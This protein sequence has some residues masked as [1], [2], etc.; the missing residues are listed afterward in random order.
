MRRSAFSRL[1]GFNVTNEQWSRAKP[2]LTLALGL[3]PAARDRLLQ[4]APQIGPDLRAE[5]ARVVREL[6]IATGRH[7]LPLSDRTTRSVAPG[8][9]GWLTRA[10]APDAPAGGPFLSPGEMCGHYRVVRFLGAGGMGQVYLAE[11]VDLGSAAALKLVSDE[12][13][14]SAEAR[15]RLRRE[16][17]RAAQ[18]RYHPHIATVLQFME[19]ELKGRTVAVLAMEYVAGHPASQLLESGPVAAAQAIRW[20]IQVARAMEFAHEKGILHCDLKPANLHVDRTAAG[21]HVKVLDFGIARALFEN[22]SA[23]HGFGTPP[24]M[25][26]EQ[27]IS[28]DCTTATDVYALGVTLFEL[29]TGRRPYHGSDALE[30]LMHVIGAPV[31]VASAIV[32]GLPRGVD[33]VLQRAIAKQPEARFSSMAEFRRELETLIRVEPVRP[34]RLSGAAV[35]AIGGLAFVTLIGF[36]TTLALDQGLGRVTDFGLS[37]LRQ[38]FFWGIRSLIAPVVFSITLLL[39]ALCVSSAVRLTWAIFARRSRAMRAV[40]ERARTR[41]ASLAA[42]TTATAGQILLLVHVGILAALAFS[43]RSLL[44]GF[45]N[46]MTNARGAIDALRPSNLAVHELYGYL[47]TTELLL[48][49]I[50]WYGLLRVRRRR[51]EREGAVYVA[52]GLVAVSLSLFLFSARFRILAHSEYE[53]V[54][55]GSETCYLIEDRGQAA[56]LFCPLAYPRNVVSDV[57]AFQRTGK[58]ESIFTPLDAR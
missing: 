6:E 46:F 10:F 15:A 56:L 9:D 23:E 25:A 16:A 27:L 17:A 21:D 40:S 28:G 30:L 50:S 18:L 22:Q 38:W 35:A 53:R 3:D 1:K 49:C 58:I 2:V 34:G 32:P 43:F 24:Y 45:M 4:S 36:V 54:V 33:A 55:Y 41:A 37:S 52:A 39:A 42:F 11:D 13:L 12:F 14:Q 5:A 19:V 48:F 51:G 57:S 20:G 31:P 7:G 8:P 29:I 44:L 26:P 47:V